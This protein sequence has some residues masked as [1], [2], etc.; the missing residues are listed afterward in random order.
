MSLFDSDRIKQSILLLLKDGPLSCHS[1]VEK[2]ANELE[3]TQEQREIREAFNPKIKAFDHAVSQCLYNLKKNNKIRQKKDRSYEIILEQPAVA[4]SYSI[5]S[6]FLKE[7]G[8]VPY[9]YPKRSKPSERIDFLCVNKKKNELIVID[10]N[11]QENPIEQIK[12]KIELVKEKNYSQQYDFVRGIIIKEKKKDCAMPIPSNL[13]NEILTIYYELFPQISENQE[14][15]DNDVIEPKDEPT[16]SDFL[17]EHLDSFKEGLLIDESIKHPREH[18][19]HNKRSI[20]IFCRDTNGNYVVIENKID[21]ET[22]YKAVGQILYYISQATKKYDK[23]KGIILVPNKNNP[24]GTKTI[25]EVLEYCKR[26]NCCKD[27]YPIEL[28][29]YSLTLCY[30]KSI[31]SLL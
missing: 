6:Y 31:L 17:F 4:S 28:R 16:F 21:C 20:D 5:F 13:D 7:L 11:P 1:I 2:T 30:D 8:F 18:P 9:I 12:R 3:I 14:Q 24:D 25:E 23:V 27:R 26:P 22:D 15:I 19:I 29:F 10:I